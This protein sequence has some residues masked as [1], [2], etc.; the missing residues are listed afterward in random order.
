LKHPVV[1]I[2]GDGQ[3]GQSLKLE[4]PEWTYLTRR[5]L[6]LSNLA[7]IERTIKPLRPHLIINAAGYTQV[8]AAETDAALARI[9]NGDA[10]E[11]LARCAP[12]Y[13]YISTDYV[14]AGNHTKPYLETEPCDPVNIYGA[15]KL[16]GEQLS[17]AANPNTIVV[18]TSWLYSRFGK[19]FVKTMLRLGTEKPI[20]R[21][22]N[23]Q[24]GRPTWA[25]DLAKTLV[26][27]SDLPTLNSG[28]YHYANSGSCTWYDFATAIFSIAK[29][30]V[31]VEPVPSREYPTPARRPEYS[32]LST[33]KIEN[34][35]GLEIPNWQSSLELALRDLIT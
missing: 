11:A 29:L 32:V 20:L 23:D 28:I 16:L 33:D 34:A 10:A 24:I 14:F 31:I 21:V 8:D 18:R 7:K 30:K 35:L 1:V 6:D 25:Q 13:C 19:N 3:L 22:V 12:K 2:G 4:R 27:M 9:V 15:S 26:R 5:D 17:M